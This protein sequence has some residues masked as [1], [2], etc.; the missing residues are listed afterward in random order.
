MSND[1]STNTVAPL[2]FSDRM[3]AVLGWIKAA[4][5]RWLWPCLAI[6]FVALFT[7]TILRPFDRS[8]DLN[9]DD[10]GLRRHTP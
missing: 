3:A 10:T 4:S 2:T 1:G 9:A 5:G 6:V 7:I 8:D